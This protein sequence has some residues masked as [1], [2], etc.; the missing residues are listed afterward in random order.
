MR[1][2]ELQPMNEETV[3][4]SE[5]LRARAAARFL[6]QLAYIETMLGEWLASERVIVACGSWADGGIAELL[7]K[8][9]ARLLPAM[10]DG[11][12]AGVRELRLDGAEHHMH[13]DLGRVHQLV[14]T[15]TPSVCFAG[16]PSFE[17]RLLTIGPGGARTSRWSVS[18]MLAC[19]Y[20]NGTLA[21]DQVQW[22][23][24]RVQLHVAQRPELVRFEV[25]PEVVRSPHGDE[26]RACLAATLGL[27][28][29]A[30]WCETLQVLDGE[31]RTASPELVEP[32]VLGVLQEALRLREASLVIY[33]ERTLVEFQTDKL[34]GIFKYVEDGHISWQ[35][36][37]VEDHHCHLALGAVT[38]VLFSAESV[39]CQAGRL[40]YTIWFLVSGSC[41]NPYRS[42]GYFSVVLNRPYLDDV[43]QPDRI[44]PM[45]DLY[46]RYQG[47]DWVDADELFLQALELGPAAANVQRLGLCRD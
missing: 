2:F 3:R 29:D 44:G 46:R 7:P 40:N 17:L 45:F 8:G 18:L 31:R 5:S 4:D 21:H 13:L 15:V 14:Y 36:G 20:T 22:F 6:E 47:A 11:C 28:N 25:S 30:P 12:F 42:D 41:G 35:I 26:V 16:R 43:P 9:K 10:Y 33:R 24:E 27:K 34:A 37:D 1:L 23:F 19:P 32:M 39:P 38:R